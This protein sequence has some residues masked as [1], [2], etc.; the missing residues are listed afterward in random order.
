VLTSDQLSFTQAA[1]LG[2]AE[3][4]TRYRI[5]LEV[6]ARLLGFAMTPA[7]SVNERSAEL[8]LFCLANAWLP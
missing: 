7:R 6:L 5:V 2:S 3:L 8:C 4:I 1:W